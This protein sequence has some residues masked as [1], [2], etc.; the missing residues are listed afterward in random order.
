MRSPVIRNT[1]LLSA[2]LSLFAAEGCQTLNTNKGKGAVI[3]AA[4]GAQRC[5]ARSSVR[6]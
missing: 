3:G 5:A 4:G 1:L 6:R 2:T